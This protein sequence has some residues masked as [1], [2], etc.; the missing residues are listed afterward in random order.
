[1]PVPGQWLQVHP[2]FE[3]LVPPLDVRMAFNVEVNEA[4]VLYVV[5]RSMNLCM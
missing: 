4:G 5:E 1:M 2:I 3:K